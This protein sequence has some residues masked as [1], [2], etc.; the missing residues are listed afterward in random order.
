LACLLAFWTAGASAAQPSGAS[1]SGTTVDPLGHAL[2]GVTVTVAPAST[3]DASTGR[4]LAATT[5]DQFGRF[6]FNDLGDGVYVITAELSGYT[7]ARVPSGRLTT[8]QSIELTVSLAVAPVSELVNVV[9]STGAGKPVEADEI[10]PNLLRVF[11]LPTD[12]FQEA[13]PL[14]P[15]V[16]RDPRGRL[17]F[18][19]TRPSQSALLVNGMNATDP[20]TGQFAIELPLSVVETVE[21]HAIPYSA[22]FGRVS[23]AVAD[24][25]TR[26]GD[27]H[28]DVEFGGL[29]PKPRF[30]DGTLK[31]I[32]TATPRLKVSGPLSPGR[33]WISQAVSYRY[34]RSRVREEI[35]GADEEIIEGF[36]AFTQIDVKLSDRHSLTGTLS[37][38]PST[39]ENQGINSL[40]PALATPDTETNGWNLA[41]ADELA[42]GP[43]TLWRTQLALRGLD[44]VVRP[45]GTGVAQLT[46]DGM[47]GTYFNTIDRQSRQLEFGLSR[48][49]SERWGG[50]THLITLG[51]QIVA[52]SFDGIDRSAPIEVR[53]SDGQLLRRI[54][55]EGSG[56][57]ESSD[58][59]S[60]GYVQDHW[61]LTG[62]L[63]VDVG[64]RF[65]HDQ[66]IGESHF[67][68]R[69]AFS[70]ALD[71][72]A[73]T[74][75]KGGWGL[76]FDQV[77]LQVDAFT[78]FQQRVE[79]EFLGSPDRPRGA[80]VVFRN[81]V[82]ADFE[83]PMS[84]VW[85]VE[86]DRQLGESLMLRIN[87][88]ENR[89][90]D[91]L[92]V[93]RAFD[94]N[95]ASLVLSSTGRLTAREFDTTLRWT[96]ADGGELYTS[97]SKIRTDGDLNDFGLVYDTV[98]QPLLLNNEVGQQA[99]DVPDRVLVW[100]ILKLPW[101]LTLTPGIEWR[102]GFLYT[103]FT[104]DYT[105]VE[106][107]NA[108]KFP[109]F[110]SADVALTKRLGLFGREADVGVQVY[111]LGSYENPRDVM[112]NQASDR[113][114]QFLNTAGTTIGLKLE[115]G[116]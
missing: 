28:W 50:R 93:N 89:A 98:R 76:F 52:T 4:F 58:V 65:D 51:T 80:P 11:Q 82:D 26:A 31:G 60:S 101:G 21:V 13:L 104:E 6:V 90:R 95:G 107:R 67:S 62:R 33:A 3:S 32:S 105:V 86:F 54:A 66:M 113:F 73:R 84:R 69:T 57:V 100:G 74:I 29:F 19:G 72:D 106:E 114:G 44:V 103:V 68:P 108:S 115:V 39:V 49:R 53:G 78:S 23:G 91:R 2:P 116:F 27:D 38:F 16:I 15:G 12:R 71:E 111:N 5:S 9:G 61:Q 8:G 102:D 83:A 59:L 63:A 42:T 7:P 37:V 25:R 99:F 75:V 94:A 64:L 85:N 30:R 55:F 77:F 48:T 92:I 47:R 41:L 56:A 109:S 79:Q 81:R 24:V 22:Q 17:S 36:D 97:F 88:R 96:L 46:P 40:T 20:V 35:P 70:L 110:F 14:L 10:E 1:L 87:Y 43:N 112:S 34:A 18:N 45:K